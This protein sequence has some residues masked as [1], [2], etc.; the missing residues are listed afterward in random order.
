MGKI[1]VA[2]NMADETM[3]SDNNKIKCMFLF[4]FSPEV[5]YDASIPRQQRS[6]CQMSV[7]T[8]IHAKLV[9]FVNPG[10]HKKEDIRIHYGHVFFPLLFLYF[11]SALIDRIPGNENI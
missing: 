10:V 7:A 5:V 2:V 8:Q 9:T 6:L 11:I 1:S 3:I 4:P